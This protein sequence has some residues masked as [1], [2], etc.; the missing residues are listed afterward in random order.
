MTKVLKTKIPY[1]VKL[2]G[3]NLI[4]LVMKIC[5]TSIEYCE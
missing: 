2:D 5:L 3:N 4:K 1:A